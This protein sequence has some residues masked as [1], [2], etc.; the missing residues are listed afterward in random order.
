MLENARRGSCQRVRVKIDIEEG[1][2]AGRGGERGRRRG[3]EIASETGS[4]L[5]TSL[6]RPRE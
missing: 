2:Y 4:K 5:K 3:G 1:R 6:A